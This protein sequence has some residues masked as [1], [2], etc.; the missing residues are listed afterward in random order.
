MQCV[1]VYY[2]EQRDSEHVGLYDRLWC[3]CRAALWSCNSFRNGN[4]VS[5]CSLHS[6]LQDNFTFAEVSGIVHFCSVFTRLRNDLLCVEWDVKL[7]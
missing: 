3:E 4:Q 2:T 5:L 1:V 6:V 7:Y